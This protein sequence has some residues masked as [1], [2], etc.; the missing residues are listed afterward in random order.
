MDRV[1]GKLRKRPT[2]YIVRGKNME[3]KKAVDEALKKWG[4]NDP[5]EPNIIRMHPDDIAEFWNE[6]SP[7]HNLGI[8]APWCPHC[9]ES[10]FT[11]ADCDVRPIKRG[12]ILV[13]REF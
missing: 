4:D 10:L 6:L 1:E 8:S 11:Y 13:G 3:I 12:V 9:K 7:S 2:K 5:R